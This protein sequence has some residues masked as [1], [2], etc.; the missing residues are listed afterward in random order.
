[1]RCGVA[2][3]RAVVTAL[4]C[5]TRNTTS[6]I[7]PTQRSHPR[8]TVPCNLSISISKPISNSAAMSSDS[9]PSTST[10]TRLTHAP[11]GGM[12][13]ISPANTGNRCPL[14]WLT[15]PLLELYEFAGS[16]WANVP[17]LAIAEA[18]YP[19][20]DIE[21]VSINLAEV[22]AAA[23]VGSSV[24]SPLLPA[25]LS[26]RLWTFG[27]RLNVTRA[28]PMLTLRLTPQGANFNPNFLKINPQGTVPTLVIGDQTWTDS[29]V[30]RRAHKP[31]HRLD[32][33]T[34]HTIPVQHLDP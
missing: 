11:I 4:S 14:C 13:W 5:S 28:L 19:T 7:Y 15:H 10:P 16:C 1:V 20:D 34:P 24:L 30:S 33:Y 29:T 23:H 9:K 25:N 27:C 18:G 3:W 6:H 2:E 12:G 8:E 21:W 32:L 17:K 22:R 26:S 31:V